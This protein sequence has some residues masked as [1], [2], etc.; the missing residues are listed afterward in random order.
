M[1]DA[2]SENEIELI[3]EDYL[4]MLAAEV[5]GRS[6]SKTEH[7]QNLLARLINRSKGSIERKHQNISAILVEMGVPYIDGYKPLRN[8]QR[9]KLYYLNGALDERFVLKPHGY[10][11]TGV[12]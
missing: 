8:Y 12:A 5:S 3:V 9:H 4:N 6:Y 7:R 2:W 10:I 1:A 11:A